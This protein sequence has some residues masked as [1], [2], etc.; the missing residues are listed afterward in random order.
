MKRYKKLDLA[1]AQKLCASKTI[2]AE[3]NYFVKTL[4][5][6]NQSEKCSFGEVYKNNTLKSALK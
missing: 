2:L 5:R 1:C 6:D 3:E 4:S